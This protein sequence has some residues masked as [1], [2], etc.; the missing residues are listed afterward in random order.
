MGTTK[1]LAIIKFYSYQV[2]IYQGVTVVKSGSKYINEQGLVELYTQLLKEENIF[3]LKLFRLSS[4]RLR[5]SWLRLSGLKVS[6]Y[7]VGEGPTNLNTPLWVVKKYHQ[8]LNKSNFIQHHLTGGFSTKKFHTRVFWLYPLTHFCSISIFNKPSNFMIW[9][10]NKFSSS[11]KTWPS[12]HFYQMHWKSWP[13]RSGQISDNY[14][15]LIYHWVTG[16]RCLQLWSMHFIGPT[17]IQLVS[18]IQYIHD[19]LFIIFIRFPSCYCIGSILRTNAT[20]V[21]QS[22]S[23]RH[24]YCTWNDPW[25]R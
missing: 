25:L 23:N 5:L 12:T 2:F 8:H 3:R 19:K 15:T 24:G 7:G 18:M 21:S 6:R 10:F 9:N 1:F 13:T 4:H 11:Y 20:Y 22:G 14:L 17:L 16:K